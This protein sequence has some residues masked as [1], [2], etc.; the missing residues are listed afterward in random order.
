MS[1]YTHENN[2]SWNIITS[3]LA[4]SVKNYECFKY[5]IKNNC[6]Y[7]INILN[8]YDLSDKFTDLLI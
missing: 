1:Y 6:P 5:L 8:N 4:A 2:C 3:T 7:D